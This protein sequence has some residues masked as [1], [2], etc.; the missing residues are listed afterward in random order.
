MVEEFDSPWFEGKVGLR[1]PDEDVRLVREIR[2]AIGAERALRLDAN[3]AWSVAAAADVLQ[4]VEAERVESIEEPVGTL[5]E[6]AELRAVTATPFS[7][8]EPDLAFAAEHGVPDAIVLNL[9][10]CGGIEGTRRFV[11]ACE[12]AGVGF[13]WYSGDLGIATAAYLH[14]SAATPYLD[15]PSQSLF[16]WYPEDVI[17]G[18]PFSAHRGLVAVPEGPGL[19]VELDETALARAVDRYARD[20]EYDLYS[21]TALPR[22]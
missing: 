1:P 12:R 8:H 13:W 11:A 19:G 3:K 18:G 6:Q 17:V 22:Y 10:V 15:R 9:G 5:A 16:R 7:S 14:V 4:R 21:G 20:G 2:A